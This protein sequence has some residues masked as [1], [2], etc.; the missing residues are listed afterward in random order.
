M[1]RGA[2]AVVKSEIISDVIIVNTITDSLT[3]LHHHIITAT[4]IHPHH[5]H[6]HTITIT[7]TLTDTITTLATIIMTISQEDS[8]AHQIITSDLIT[9]VLSIIM[10]GMETEEISPIITRTAGSMTSKRDSS[11]TTTRTNKVDL[12]T[13]TT[14]ETRTTRTKGASIL[15][16]TT[17]LTT[18][19]TLTIP[20][21]MRSL[22]SPVSD[23]IYSISN[24][25][26][27]PNEDLF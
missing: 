10:G 5:L 13:R 3:H 7:T 24:P 22:A 14:M 1:N 12:I 16:Q 15:N 25:N 18:M 21:W 23:W 20:I 2:G 27:F 26:A 11:I 8:A 9:D 17:N 4:D 19:D 6:S